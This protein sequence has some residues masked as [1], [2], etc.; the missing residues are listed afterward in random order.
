MVT[1]SWT[2]QAAAR[3]AGNHRFRLLS[4]LR[5]HTK[6]PYEVD[7]HRET[8]RVLNRLKAARTVAAEDVEA[9]PTDLVLEPAALGLGLYPTVTLAN[10]YYIC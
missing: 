2:K 7:F 1:R 4:A 6:A 9:V 5:A 10:R 8:R 3:G